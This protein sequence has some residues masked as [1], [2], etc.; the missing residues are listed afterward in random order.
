MTQPREPREQVNHLIRLYHRGVICPS[1]MW[2]QIAWALTSATAADVLESLP[3]EVKEQLQV[4]W[5]D[6]PP[7]VYV[8]GAD[9][10]PEED[11]SEVCAQIVRWCQANF[12][13][14]DAPD[15]DDGW[16]RVHVLD[17]VVQ[18]W[19]PWETDDNTKSKNRS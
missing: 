17:G 6:R 13:M 15:H 4:V 14:P 1:E 7:A 8:E 2:R 9:P 11:W 5:L 18:R 12:P 3:A 19:R 10:S 16:I